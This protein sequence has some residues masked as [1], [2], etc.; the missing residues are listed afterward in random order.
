MLTLLPEQSPLLFICSMMVPV[1]TCH[2]GSGGSDGSLESADLI[3]NMQH[4]FLSALN[5]SLFCFYVHP[6]K[7]T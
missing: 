1:L 4:I 3:S 6:L 2:D 5:N 7:P